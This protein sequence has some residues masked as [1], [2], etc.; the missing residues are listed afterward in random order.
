MQERKTSVEIGKYYEDVAAQFLIDKGYTIL[1]RNYRKKYEGEIDIIC[2]RD[3]NIVFVEVKYRKS[4]RYGFP[5]EFITYK[6][7]NRIITVSKYY[8]MEEYNY[9]AVYT[10]DVIEIC[11]DNINH[12]ENA[13]FGG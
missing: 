10:Y 6:K 12:I 7:Q 2:Q 13:F 3:D 5:R 11:N 8:M 4:V 9:D 1:K